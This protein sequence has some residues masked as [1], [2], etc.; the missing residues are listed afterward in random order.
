MEFEWKAF[1]DLARELVT[2]GC[3]DSSVLLADPIVC[4][5]AIWF[6]GVRD[7]RSSEQARPRSRRLCHCEGLAADEIGPSRSCVRPALLPGSS[8]GR[9][10][11]QRLQHAPRT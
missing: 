4:G 5:L 7:E 2:I 11:S 8:A 1:L 6:P 9:L 3:P 10:H